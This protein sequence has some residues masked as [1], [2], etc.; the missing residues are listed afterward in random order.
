MTADFEIALGDQVHQT[1]T[2]R[3]VVCHSGPVGHVKNDMIVRRV[4]ARFLHE[5]A[6]LRPVLAHMFDR[7]S[8]AHTEVHDQDFTAREMSTQ[9]LGPARQT[10]KA[11]PL[12]PIDEM[13]GKRKSQICT[14][15][16]DTAE[17]CALHCRRKATTDGFDF[18][19]LGQF[20]RSI[21]RVVFRR[22]KH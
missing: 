5:L 18:W 8:S 21:D 1:E 10:D 6:D 11:Y 9:I 4:A 2:A 3:V 16:L 12:Q 17:G 7:K 22:R 20:Q 15:T 13:I 14:A 19:K